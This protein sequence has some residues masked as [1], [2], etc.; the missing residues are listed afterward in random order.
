MLIPSTPLDITEGFPASI[1]SAVT[2]SYPPDA[3]W[4]VSFGP[5]GFRLRPGEGATYRRATEQVRKQQIDT[6]ENAGEQSFTSWWFR[7]QSSWDRGAGIRWFDPRVSPAT[8]DR[9]A[10]SSG[11]D[12]WTQGEVSLLRRMDAD[13]FGV[14]PTDAFVSSFEWNGVPGV[15]EA[16][17]STIRWAPLGG[18]VVAQALPAAAASQP[19]AAGDVAFVG[20]ESGVSRVSPTSVTPFVSSS[21]AARAW[22]VKSRVFIAVGR[23]LYEVP[24]TASGAVTSA[25]TNTFTHPSSGWVWTDVTE[26]AGAVLA[27]G[28]SGSASAIFRFTVEN[29][30]TGTPVLRGPSQVAAL[31]PGE[32][33]TC[34]GVYLGTTVVLG[35]SRGVRVGVVSDSGDVQYGPLTVE[36]GQPV[37]DVTF[38][39][40][41]AYLSVTAALPAGVS[42]A[43]RVDLSTQVEEGG[44]HAWAWDAAT[45]TPQ[46]ATSIALVGDRVVI[47]AGRR[48]FAQGDAPVPEGWLDSGRVRFATAEPKAFRLLRSVV[49]TN[50]G[51]A[52][53]TVVT[54]D[55]VEHRVVTLTDAFRTEEDLPVVTVGRPVNQYLSVRVVLR[56][57]EAGASPVLSALSLKAAPAGGRVRLFQFPVS[58]YDRE[59]LRWGSTV[60]VDGGAFLR[61]SALE[62]LE[63]TGRPVQVVD[64]RT[65]ES[66]AGQIDSVD[67]TAVQPPDGAAAN[68]EGTAV[69]VVRRL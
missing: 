56:P 65:G 60:G 59:V 35:T 50:G 53:L 6:S 40:R 3:G 30:E 27:S 10:D 32:R 7:T 64:H 34:M 68:M 17:G 61:L 66:F 20:H 11:V 22:W 33:V 18:T 45:D 63:E 26:T 57:S 13:G 36:T 12:V 5:L 31:P 43:V 19:A 16:A 42:G 47:A 39:D 21:G 4:D 38:R 67:F 41:F 15:L 49:E 28:F 1:G 58:V 14:R 9:F 24:A 29:D 8:Q 48:L 69:V 55:G 2:D 46:P 23:T 52:T 51:E 44:P 25:A 62:D 37:T 54:P